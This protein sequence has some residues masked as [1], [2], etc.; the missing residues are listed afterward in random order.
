MRKDAAPQDSVA[1]KLHDRELPGD[2]LV[3]RREL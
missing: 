2:P 1:R 3:R